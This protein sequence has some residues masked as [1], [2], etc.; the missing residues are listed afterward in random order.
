M[1]EDDA[2]LAPFDALS[3]T[4][5]MLKELARLA[6]IANRPGLDAAIAR[7]RE[8]TSEAIEALAHAQVGNAAPGDAA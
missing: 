6:A 4:Y 3:Y 1:E 7:A 8:E 5:L 2:E